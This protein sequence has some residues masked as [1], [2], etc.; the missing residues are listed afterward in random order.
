MKNSSAPSAPVSAAA[1]ISPEHPVPA[2][3]P[4]L[5]IHDHPIAR[6]GDGVCDDEAAGFTLVTRSKRG[7]APVAQ[8]DD[9][10]AMPPPS[11]ATSEFKDPFARARARTGP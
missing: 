1:A 4:G 10:G 8:K 11:P 6:S 9:S 5:T 7:R 3:A 2:S